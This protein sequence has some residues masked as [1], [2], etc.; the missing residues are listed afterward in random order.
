[1]FH[2]YIYCDSSA[3]NCECAVS[4][5]PKRVHTLLA[6]HW[7]EH[8]ISSL[9]TEQLLLCEVRAIQYKPNHDK[10]ENITNNWRMWDSFFSCFLFYSIFCAFCFLH[11]LAR[12]ANASFQLKRSLLHT[13][14]HIFAQQ[15]CLLYIR[16]ILDIQFFH[17]S[18]FTRDFV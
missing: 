3:R 10:R 2:W 16:R 12:C 18:I 5:R 8:T 6:I 14:L 1:M 15:R 17:Y 11:A 4:S 7:M 9:S 13:N